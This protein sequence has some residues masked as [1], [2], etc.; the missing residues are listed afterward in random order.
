MDQTGG[1][2]MNYR[3][4]IGVCL[5]L[6]LACFT[7][8][9]STSAPAD[10]PSVSPADPLACNAVCATLTDNTIESAQ[11]TFIAGV[12]YSF[13]VTNK[14]KAP[15]NFI[16]QSIPQGPGG[17]YNEILYMMNAI[18]PGE[19]RSFIFNFPITAPQTAIEFSTTLD[20]GSGSVVLLPVQANLG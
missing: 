2:T 16:I 1:I 14:G 11:V 18:P 10:P 6:C 5:V 19:S 13:V 15:H 4:G 3:K 12:S 9:A 7:A 8:C 17:P 20:D